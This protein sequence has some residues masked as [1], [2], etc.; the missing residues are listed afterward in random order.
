MLIS[1]NNISH[2]IVSALFLLQ[3]CAPTIPMLKTKAQAMP[4]SFPDELTT[5]ENSAD[6]VWKEFYQDQQLNGLIDLALKNNQELSIL[7]QEIN[8]ANN[9]IM[10]RQ[11]EYLPKFNAGV[12]GGI[13]KAERFSTEDANSAT[14][15]GHLGVTTSWE[16]DI[17][18]KLRNATKSAYYNYLG[19]IETRKYLVTNVVAE[20]ANSY[21]ELMALDNQHTI[22]DSYVSVLTQIKDMVL[23]QQSA[24]RVTS[25]PVKRFEAEV[26][27]NKARQYQIKQRITVA[28]NK[29]NLLLG[30]YPQNISR[31]SKHFIEIA[32]TKIR[33]SVPTKLLDNRPDIKRASLELMAAKLNVK[34]AKAR[35]YP[36]LSIDGSYGWEQF[37]SK[38]FDGTP[39]SIFY[40]IAANLTAPILNRKGIEADY[41]SANNKQ[42]QAVYNYEKTMIQAYGEVVNQLSMI[43]NYNTVYEMKSN[44]VKALNESIEISNTLFRAARV[45]YI[46]S[47]MTQRDSLEAQIELVDVKR[48]Q[49]SSYVNLYKA[50]G[51]GW[52]GLEEKSVSNY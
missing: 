27:K 37:N 33:S 7:E 31:D 48:D 6:V 38:H 10:S 52:K 40:G 3:A 25:L 23:L 13:E 26:L 14:K 44:Q 49:L 12:G 8:I 21:Y 19:S 4:K 18:K 47:L 22:V 43:K 50:L 9:E 46:E 41:R 32:F 28:Q 5:D 16:V 17:W 35:F 51:G 29:L 11:G 30:R 42:V 45:D 24:G 2:L 34:V 20:V 36:S 39:T 15:F 1:K